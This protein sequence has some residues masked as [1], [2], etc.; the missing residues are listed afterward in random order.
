MSIVNKCIL[1][2]SGLAMVHMYRDLSDP[3]VSAIAISIGQ[4]RLCSARLQQHEQSR[5]V[6]ELEAAATSI[7]TANVHVDKMRA[8][9]ETLSQTLQDKVERIEK[10]RGEENSALDFIALHLANDSPIRDLMQRISAAAGGGLG[11]GSGGSNALIP[12]GTASLLRITS[13]VELQRVERAIQ[14]RRLREDEE[15]EWERD[16]W[17]REQCTYYSSRLCS[18]WALLHD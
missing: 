12:R 17:V 7:A 8:R 4:L 15:L 18:A 3:R 11:S 2:C 5:K 13:H 16:R 14:A 10:Q 1:L 6:S 9:W